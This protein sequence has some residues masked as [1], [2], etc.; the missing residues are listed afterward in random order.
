MGNL[1]EKK[2]TPPPNQQNQNTQSNPNQNLNRLNNPLIQSIVE[3]MSGENQKSNHEDDGFVDLENEDL[4]IIGGNNNS[5][6]KVE[7]Q[8]IDKNMEN[9]NKFNK[10]K[11]KMKNRN[12]N[13]NKKRLDINIKNY[14]TNNIPMGETARNFYPKKIIITKKK[15]KKKKKFQILKKLAKTFMLIMRKM[16][17]TIYKEKEKSH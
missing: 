16:K 9:K 4:A 6:N 14:G 10:H 2:E 1:F 15:K 7:N 13:R 12:N 11:D 5:N 17:M 8:N 3:D